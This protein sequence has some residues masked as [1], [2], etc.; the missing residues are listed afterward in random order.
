MLLALPTQIIPLI[1][2]FFLK[3]W[4]DK[5]MDNFHEISEGRRTLFVQLHLLLEK[6]PMQEEEWRAT[7]K[8]APCSFYPRNRGPGHETIFI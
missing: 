4:K 6:F 8:T 1:S 5:I 7:A 2:I 3:F